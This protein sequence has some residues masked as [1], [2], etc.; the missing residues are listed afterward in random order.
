MNLDTY[1]SVALDGDPAKFRSRSFIQD[2]LEKLEVT[3]EQ[4]KACTN[5]I[6]TS[7]VA[8]IPDHCRNAIIP[9]L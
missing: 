1:C 9:L 8:I 3:W 2:D 5:G 7:M 6:L 4:L